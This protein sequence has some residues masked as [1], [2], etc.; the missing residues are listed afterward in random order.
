MR[1]DKYEYHR[2]SNHDHTLPYYSAHRRVQAK[3]QQVPTW[4]IAGVMIGLS[5]VIFAW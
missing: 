5:L 2:F 4:I 1:H 3:R